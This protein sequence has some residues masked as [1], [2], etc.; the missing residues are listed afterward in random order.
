MHILKGKEACTALGNLML[1]E[2]QKLVFRSGKVF[3]TNGKTSREKRSKRSEPDTAV[4]LPRSL[5]DS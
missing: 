4:S 3:R 2:K 5:P 1:L